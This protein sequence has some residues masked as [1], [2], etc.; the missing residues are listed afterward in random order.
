[1]QWPH[2]FVYRICKRPQHTFHVTCFLCHV[3]RNWRGVGSLESTENLDTRGFGALMEN[4]LEYRLISH[5]RIKLHNKF[6]ECENLFLSC[7][8]FLVFYI[9]IYF[10]YG[11]PGCKNK[12]LIRTRFM[13]E[14]FRRWRTTVGR[15]AAAGRVRLNHWI[16]EYVKYKNGSAT[17]PS[18]TAKKSKLFWAIIRKLSCLHTLPDELFKPAVDYFSFYFK[19]NL[20]VLLFLDQHSKL[21][22]N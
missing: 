7:I 12:S 11:K 5:L 22:F 18:R 20:N 2:G 9:F 8:S 3:T 13:L 1:M 21:I 4:E 19:F 16:T 6:H 15:Q 14:S 17:K 10:F